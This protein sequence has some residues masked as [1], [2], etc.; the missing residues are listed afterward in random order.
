MISNMAS[1]WLM[2][3]L[4]ASQMPGF[5]ILFKHPWISTWKFLNNQGL[6]QLLRPSKISHPN[7]L[8]AVDEQQNG[9]AYL[10]DYPVFPASF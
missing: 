3:V 1:D 5:K 6:K 9:W 7:Q 4:P 2:T 8:R 10:P